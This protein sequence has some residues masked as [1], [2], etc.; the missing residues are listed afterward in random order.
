MRGPR[1]RI[2]TTNVRYPLPEDGAVDQGVV[3]HRRSDGGSGKRNLANGLA[4]NERHLAT[5]KRL[6]IVVGNAQKRVLKIDHVS[7]HMNGDDLPCAFGNDLVPVHKA[8]AQKTAMGGHI[9]VA[10]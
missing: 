8:C 5:C 1:S 10:N 3:P 9:S 6:H 4:R 2:T 7:S